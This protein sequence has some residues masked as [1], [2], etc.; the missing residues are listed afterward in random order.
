MYIQTLLSIRDI[1]YDSVAQVGKD[2]ETSAGP[3]KLFE[4]R[5]GSWLWSGLLPLQMLIHPHEIH[6]RR[7][8][9]MMQVGLVLPTIRA[10]S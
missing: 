2:V 5:E 1:I 8:H 10:L 6:S 4:G 3:L 7:N 9:H